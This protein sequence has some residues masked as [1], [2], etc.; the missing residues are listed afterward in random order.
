MYSVYENYFQNVWNNKKNGTFYFHDAIDLEKDQQDK[1]Q[2]GALVPCL[3]QRV[4]HYPPT[5]LI[6]PSL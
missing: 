6:T 5:Q 2:D 3:R 1:L 4:V